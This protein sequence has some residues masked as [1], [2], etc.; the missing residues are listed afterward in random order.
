M[1]ANK[2]Y[3]E[4]RNIKGAVAP[5]TPV[6][7]V[8]FTAESASLEK[9]NNMFLRAVGLLH[10]LNDSFLGK[11]PT[12]DC[13]DNFDP[14]EHQSMRKFRDEKALGHFVQYLEFLVRHSASPQA[15]VTHDE[16]GFVYGTANALADISFTRDAS[17]YWTVE[18]NVSLTSIIP[19]KDALQKEG[20]TVTVQ[21]AKAA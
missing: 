14:V 21:E 7:N 19:V 15:T 12:C 16:S 4:N 20:F 6:Y 2:K 18:G 17:G 9:A 13:A 11:R 5:G 8:A 10:P 1:N 3:G